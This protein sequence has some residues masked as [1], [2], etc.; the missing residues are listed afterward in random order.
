[1]KNKK[2]TLKEIINGT[3]TGEQARR[4][5]RNVSNQFPILIKWSNDSYSLG[6]GRSRLTEEQAKQELGV[7]SLEGIVKI[8]FS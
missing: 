1:M 7:D 2:H 8:S 5:L 3:I 6:I 4:E